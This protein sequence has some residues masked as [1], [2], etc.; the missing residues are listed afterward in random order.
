MGLDQLRGEIDAH[1]LTVRTNAHRPSDEARRHR[2]ERAL[3]LH[4]MIWMH[5][6]A[7]G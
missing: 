6:V 4:V 2:V 7:A 5:S 3:N 1:Q